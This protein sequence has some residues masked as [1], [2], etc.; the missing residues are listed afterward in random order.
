V[1]RSKSVKYRREVRYDPKS[2]QF[3]PFLAG[4]S[5]GELDFSRDGKWITYVSYPEQALWRSRVD[6]SDRLQLTYPP[7]L[8]SLPHWSPAPP[9]SPM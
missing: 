8:A 1:R 6:G 3:A 9:R 2:K 7:V 4:I 5:A